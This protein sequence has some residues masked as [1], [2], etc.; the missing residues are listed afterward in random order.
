LRN[1]NRCL[2]ATY[3]K[4]D[5]IIAHT[6]K[7]NYPTMS[8]GRQFILNNFRS[9]QKSCNSVRRYCASRNVRGG[10]GHDHHAHEH[11]APLGPYEV[12]HHATYPN[13]AFLFGID[14][15]KP[16]QSEGWEVLT[17]ATYFLT[18]GIIFG[19]AA[20]KDLDSFKVSCENFFLILFN[21][22]W[23]F[24]HREI[25]SLKDLGKTRGSST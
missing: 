8:L 5:K 22:S 13:Q 21:L 10:H 14:P 12:P 6:E 25:S 9:L 19:T 17:F 1:R 23:T 16:Y 2:T 11:H 3:D 24:H 7:I 15:S 18:F 4:A 20:A